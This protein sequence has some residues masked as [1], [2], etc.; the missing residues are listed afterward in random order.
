MD[1]LQP[2]R[3]ERRA[4]VVL[5]RRED[6][7]ADE[8][9]IRPHELRHNGRKTDDDIRHDVGAHDV[10]AVARQRLQ[11]I[12]ILDDVARPRR[13][14]VRAKAVLRRIRRGDMLRARVD[15]DAD[16]ACRAEPQGTDGKDAAAGCLGR[17]DRL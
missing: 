15:V 12:R 17:A 5:P 6:A 11:K 16:G 14:A 7:A 9:R 2:G 10:K 13:E 4:H 1:D 8:R 3:R